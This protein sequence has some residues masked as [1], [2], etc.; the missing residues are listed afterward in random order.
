MTT[1]GI[2]HMIRS[3]NLGLGAVVFH[4]PGSLGCREAVDRRY[5]HEQER[6]GSILN[7]PRT[8]RL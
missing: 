8:Y 7:Q 1:F 6:L 4:L 3:P 5:S 2:L